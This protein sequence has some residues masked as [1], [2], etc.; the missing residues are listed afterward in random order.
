MC[1][2]DWNFLCAACEPRHKT[3]LTLTAGDQDP[4]TLEEELYAQRFEL[5]SLETLR[6]VLEHG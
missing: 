2:C 4:P 6:G 1:A 5:S 3:D